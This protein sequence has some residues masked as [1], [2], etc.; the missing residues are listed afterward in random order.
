M[1]CYVMLCYVM[2]GGVVSCRVVLCCAVSCCFVLFYFM[3]CYV[4]LQSNHNV[5]T[6]HTPF[7]KNKV[8]GTPRLRFEVILIKNTQALTQILK[9]TNYKR[10]CKK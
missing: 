6:T 10:L 1:L 8:F 9:N 4:M 2:L 7:C 3:L 5:F